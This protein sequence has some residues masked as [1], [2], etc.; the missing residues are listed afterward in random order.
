M[1]WNVAIVNTALEGGQSRSCA[2]QGEGGKLG[3]DR[4]GQ[5]R[6]ASRDCR[7]TTASESLMLSPAV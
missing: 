3:A 5:F 1:Y 4:R 7:Q 2:T 6:A